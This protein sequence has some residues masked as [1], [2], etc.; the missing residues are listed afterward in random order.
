MSVNNN[1][2]E[3]S[4]EGSTIGRK[5]LG[6]VTLSVILGV[7][8]GIAYLGKGRP[9]PWIG[10]AIVDAGSSWH[11]TIVEVTI[12]WAFL[13]NLVVFIP[14]YIFQTEKFYDLTGSLT[15]LSCTWYSYSAGLQ[16]SQVL[17]RPTIASV[18]VSLWAMRLGW[19]LFNRILQ[20]GK[21]GR[22][23]EIKPNFVRFLNVWA[24]QGLWVSLTAYAVFIANASSVEGSLGATDIIGIIVWAIGWAIEVVADRQKRIWRADPSNKGKFIED[25]LWY[26]SRHP[27]YAGEVQLWLGMFI[28]CLGAFEG[29]Q[30]TAVISPIFVFCL[31]FFLSG[32]PMLEKG[33]DKK[34]GHLKDYQNY[35]ATTSVFLVLPKLGKRIRQEGVVDSSSAGPSTV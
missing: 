5:I 34:W 32:V 26:Y 28:L 30:W 2:G 14:A 20:D 1:S 18:F 16:G 7:G 10:Q 11:P 15:Y 25:G 27:N 22:F 19:F 12:A 24:L 17:A 35:K 29:T 23:D 33:A 4:S 31:I 8:A 6:L 13:V 3:V 9:D 21:D